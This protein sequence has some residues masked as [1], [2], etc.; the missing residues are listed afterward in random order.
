[1][2]GTTRVTVVIKLIWG[3]QGRFVFHVPS[4][5]VDPSDAIITGLITVLEAIT[6]GKAIHIEISL[7]AATSATVT[8]GVAYVSEDKALMRFK[9]ENGVG[10]AYKVL[11]LLAALLQSDK[12]TINPSNALVLAYRAAVLA[13]AKTQNGDDITTFVSGHRVENR[14]PI[15]KGRV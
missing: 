15:K 13:N 1:M 4:T 8:T 9:D 5:V 12:E 10:H 14:K 7:S 6:R 3:P 2:A 11:G